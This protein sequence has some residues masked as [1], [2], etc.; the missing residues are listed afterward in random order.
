MPAK[1]RPVLFNEDGSM[2]PIKWVPK[3]ITVGASVGPSGCVDCK[4]NVYLIMECEYIVNQHVWEAAGL[5]QWRG[6]L[7]CIGC[8]E[9]R[10]GRRLE[11]ADFEL[12][13]PLTRAGM[14]VGSYRLRDRLHVNPWTR[15]AHGLARR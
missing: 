8:L 15:R 11:R 14:R 3:G 13:N 7:L 6:G 5:E 4:V 1:R 2:K 10:I 9:V 12:S